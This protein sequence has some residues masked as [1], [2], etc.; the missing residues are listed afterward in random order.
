MN[1]ADAIKLAELLAGEAEHSGGGIW[2][3]RVAKPA[4]RFVIFSDEVVNEYADEEAFELG[5][6][7][8]SIALE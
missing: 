1:E 2:L 7:L 5:R 4:G 3:V 6:P 8:R